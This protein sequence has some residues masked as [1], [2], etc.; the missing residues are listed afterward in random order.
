MFTFGT[1][2]LPTI[3]HKTSPSGSHTSFQRE[4][5]ISKYFKGLGVEVGKDR[6]GFGLSLDGEVGEAALGVTG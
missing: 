5:G 3:T 4:R 6:K 1:P 2:C